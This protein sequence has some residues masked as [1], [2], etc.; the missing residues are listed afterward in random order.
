MGDNSDRGI[1]TAV[2]KLT[3]TY[4]LEQLY[5][6]TGECSNIDEGAGTCD[7]LAITGNASTLISGVKFQAA[8]GDGVDFIPADGSIVKVLYSKYTV[9]FVVQYSDIH[10]M[11]LAADVLISDYGQMTI[12]ADDLVANIDQIKI[13]ADNIVLNGGGFGG[14]VKVI[15]LTE[16]LNNLENDINS[17][18]LL[19]NTMISAMLAIT[20]GNVSH[21][22]LNA[23]FSPLLP[24][25]LQVI[26]PTQKTQLENPKITH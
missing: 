20:S 13:N 8:V 17:L 2:R 1:M 12:K 5:L 19:L 26:I 14:L 7:V 4:D 9:P 24:Y 16:K 11:I 22:E 6:I 10:K 25:S 18:K 21:T 3:G 23:F 15:V